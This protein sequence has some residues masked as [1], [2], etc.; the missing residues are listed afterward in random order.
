MKLLSAL[1]FLAFIASRHHAAIRQSALSA[2]DKI[3][4]WGSAT[5]QPQALSSISADICL[6]ALTDDARSGMPVRIH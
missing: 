6:A 4:G 5:R 2:S 1:L 3:A